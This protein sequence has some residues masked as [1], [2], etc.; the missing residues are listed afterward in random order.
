MAQTLV[1]VSAHLARFAT[2]QPRITLGTAGLVLL[3]LLT[4]LLG[5]HSTL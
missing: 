5:S 3:E 1:S 2:R 4:I